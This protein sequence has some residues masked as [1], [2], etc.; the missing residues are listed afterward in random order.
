M[1]SLGIYE[2]IVED[3]EKNDNVQFYEG[4]LGGSYWLPDDIKK[5]MY[6]FE[7][8][9]NAVVYAVLFTRTPIGAMWSM[10]YVSDS[11]DEWEMDREDLK[12]GEAYAYV[13]NE[14]DPDLSEIGLVGFK[15]NAGGTLTRTY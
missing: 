4:P 5:V 2:P 6:D 8:N 12:H 10:L 1:R 14:S 9:Y 15:K 7:D 3:F 13:Y 11:E